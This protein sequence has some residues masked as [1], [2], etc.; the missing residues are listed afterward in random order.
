[1]EWLG[2]I[3][4]LSG[5]RPEGFVGF[6]TE[7]TRVIFQRM[8]TWIA[9]LPKGPAG[10]EGSGTAGDGTSSFRSTGAYVPMTL[11]SLSPTCVRVFLQY[12][13]E[14]NVTS[15]A[16]KVKRVAPAGPAPGAVVPPAPSPGVSQTPSAVSTLDSLN[17][18]L[19]MTTFPV[20]G[21]LV[22]VT[23]SPTGKAGWHLGSLCPTEFL[24]APCTCDSIGPSVLDPALSPLRPELG[25]HL[26]VA[27]QVQSRT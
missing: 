12:L 1:M 5:I 10:L 8:C 13:M 25:L 16:L 21:M 23:P 20:L 3:A 2:R 22:D 27:L 17:V 6:S 9:S 14:C 4:T 15:G 7:V 11:A 26:V 24:A 18:D 19:S